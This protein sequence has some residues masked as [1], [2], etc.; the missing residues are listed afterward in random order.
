MLSRTI[1]TLKYILQEYRFYFCIIIFLLSLLV[2]NRYEIL[3][4]EKKRLEIDKELYQLEVKSERRQKEYD[5]K[6]K[7]QQAEIERMIKEIKSHE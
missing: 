1:E 2:Y 5:E 6:M 4:V 3:I 7:Q